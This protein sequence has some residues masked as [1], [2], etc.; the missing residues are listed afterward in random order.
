MEPLTLDG[1]KGRFLTGVLSGVKR[2]GI[3][4]EGFESASGVKDI[5]GD[6]SISLG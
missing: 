1:E 5:F 2:L 4:G 3:S 6:G